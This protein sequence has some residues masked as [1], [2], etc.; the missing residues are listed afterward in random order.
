MITAPENYKVLVNFIPLE[1]TFLGNVGP[2]RYCGKSS[3]DVEFKKIAHA[4]PELV[5]NK[6]LF[7]RDECDSCNSFFD[8]NLENNLANFLGILR[9]TTKIKGKGGVPKFKSADGERVEIVGDDLI[10]I[11]HHD[12]SMVQVDDRNKHISITTEKSSYIPLAV[13]KCFVKMALAI[14]PD[15]ERHGYRHTI[16]WIVGGKKPPA[17]NVRA[18]KVSRTFVNGGKYM[19]SLQI[20]LLKRTKDEKINP[21]LFCLVSFNNLIFQFF[22]P[23]G[24][25]DKRLNY[26]KMNLPPIAKP[27]TGRGFMSTSASVDIDLSGTNSVRESDTAYMHIPEEFK[28]VEFDEVPEAIKRRIEKLGLSFEPP[29]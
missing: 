7:S 17:F 6:F 26:E 9:T 11:E 5:G 21:N 10:L 14:L 1:K 13:Y 23:F 12:S 29:A 27:F 28:S 25:K 22:V 8:K 24:D 20:M 15:H 18:L 16:N 19:P 3:E 2:C 4:L